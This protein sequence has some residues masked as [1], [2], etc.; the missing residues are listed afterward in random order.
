M[1]ED[2][3]LPSISLVPRNKWHSQHINLTE[4][5]KQKGKKIMVDLRYVLKRYI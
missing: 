3:I 1:L 5:E 2:F 4:R